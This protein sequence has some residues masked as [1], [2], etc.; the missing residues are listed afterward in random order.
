MTGHFA[1]GQKVVWDGQVWEINQYVGDRVVLTR[2]GMVT[3]L[4]PH[5]TEGFYGTTK[6]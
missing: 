5:Y 2:A 3:C 1:I 6:K 4:R